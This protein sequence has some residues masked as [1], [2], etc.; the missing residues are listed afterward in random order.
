MS[1]EKR[2]FLEG[3]LKA[4]AIC[5][6]RQRAIFE[7]VQKFVDG[8]ATRTRCG[9][10]R[11]AR[12]RCPGPRRGARPAEGGHAGPRPESGRRG[13]RGRLGGGGG[14]AGR[15]HR[16]RRRGA[17][18]RGP[19][20]RGRA[21]GVAAERCRGGRRLGPRALRA[22][23]TTRNAPWRR[24]MERRLRRAQVR[25]ALGDEDARACRPRRLSSGRCWPT[26][27]AARRT[28]SAINA[29]TRPLE[30]PPLFATTPA[31]AARRQLR[32]T[33]RRRPRRAAQARAVCAAAAVPGRRGARGG[34]AASHPGGARGASRRLFS[35][36]T[37]GFLSPAI[38]CFLWYPVPAAPRVGHRLAQLL[39][40]AGFPAGCAGRL[41]LASRAPPRPP[42]GP[43]RLAD[44]TS[45]LVELALRFRTN[46]SQ[47]TAT[48]SVERAFCSKSSRHPLSLFCKSLR[49]LRNARAREAPAPIKPAAAADKKQPSEPINKGAPGARDHGRART[50]NDQVRRG[51]LQR[52]AASWKMSLPASWAAKPAANLST[53][54]RSSTRTTPTTRS[55]REMSS[56]R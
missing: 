30:A 15:G 25:P 56:Q 48:E 13:R 2:R 5:A 19:S 32:A 37:Y 29:A 41:R 53:T 52:G 28:G 54:S 34:S 50:G 38:G 26:T 45:G 17:E 23:A 49:L 35:C 31:D 4:R 11:A 55:M 24:S 51:S 12:G 20:G 36:G 47:T 44:R 3:A 16:E 1:E 22:C 7:A 10:A 46:S 43:T 39:K 8:T 27:R 40:A 21:M 9:R 6:E 33:A 42:P 18:R 14:V